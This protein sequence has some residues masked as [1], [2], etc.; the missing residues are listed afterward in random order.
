MTCNIS[1]LL[2]SY[3]QTNFIKIY[4][5]IGNTLRLNVEWRNKDHHYAL[6]SELSGSGSDTC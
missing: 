2:T 1:I 3:L 6:V 5:L 4:Q